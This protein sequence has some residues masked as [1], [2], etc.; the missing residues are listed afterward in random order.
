MPPTADGR[1]L[2]WSSGIWHRRKLEPISLSH[3]TSRLRKVADSQKQCSTFPEMLPSIRNSKAMSVGGGERASPRV[4]I[5]DLPG[6]ATW[7]GGLEDLMRFV[8][9]CALCRVESCLL[10]HQPTSM[11][12]TNPARQKMHKTAFPCQTSI[13]WAT[14]DPCQRT[15]S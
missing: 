15:I 14:C 4:D 6:E 1:W 2:C 13:R 10:H 5:S 12:H 7:Q 3:C 8:K 11:S 9:P